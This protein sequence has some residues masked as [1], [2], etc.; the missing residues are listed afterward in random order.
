MLA[1][2][3]SL[4]FTSAQANEI[5][6]VSYWLPPAYQQVANAD[7]VIG[8][9]PWTITNAAPRPDIWEVSANQLGPNATYSFNISATKDVYLKTLSFGL[10]TNDCQNGGPVFCT[11]DDTVHFDVQ[12]SSDNINFSTL[13]T[14][15]TAPLVTTDFSFDLNQPLLANTTAYFR[16][17]ASSGS[18]FVTTSRY[19][20][21]AI[22]VQG[23]PVPATLWLFGTG[24]ALL[25]RRGKAA[26][27]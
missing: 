26:S 16:F 10:Y 8:S 27:A 1:V 23:L 5:S 14:V 13:G 7:G 21:N 20:F 19:A 25:A 4:M 9:W 6:L 24:L 15:F 3:G 2:A 12:I 17:V 18:Q 11:A 22:N